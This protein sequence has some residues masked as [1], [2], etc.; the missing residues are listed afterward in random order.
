VLAIK[1]VLLNLISLAAAFG[2]V[3]FV[4]QQGHG[5]SL[6]NLDATQS[7]TAWIPVMI[8]AFLFGLSVDYEVFMLSRMREA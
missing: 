8:F 5:S 6:W 7:V 2:I 4:F 3:V 1:A